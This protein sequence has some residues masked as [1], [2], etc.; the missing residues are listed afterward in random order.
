MSLVLTVRRSRL[1]VGAYRC[2]R[3]AVLVLGCVLAVV[4]EA[5]AQAASSLAAGGSQTCV[6]TAG[7]AV[8]CWGS[9]YAGLSSD[10]ES[11]LV[12]ISPTPTTVS[13]L[14][15]GVASVVVGDSHACAL[16][17]GGA[18]RCWGD[19]SSG[20]LGDGTTT[21]RFTPTAV[22]GLGSGVAA[23][24]AGDFHTCALTTGG[25]VR[26]W[27]A[28]FSGQLG[29]G[30]T[31]Y[32]LTPTF[33]SG[34]GSVAAVAVSGGY[35]HTC[36]LLATGAA[37]CWGSNFSGQ[38]GDGTTTTRSTP[39]AVSGL[40]SGVAAVAAR[41]SH[42]C[43]VTTGGALLCWGDNS[44][45]QLGDGT[46]TNRSTP[47][48]VSGLGAGVAAVSLGS[49]HTCA[50]TS[51]G[52]VRCWG[53]NRAGQLG[54]G[55]TNTYRY[56]PTEVTGLGAGVAALALG[57]SHSCARMV[58]GTVRCW[59]SNRGGQL[60]DGTASSP[61]ILVP[62]AS[63]LRSGVTALTA[64]RE[65]TC[66]AS[67]GGALLC[68]GQ[69]RSGQLGDGTSPT[70][71]STPTTVSGLASGVA[72]A[73]AGESHT[74]ALT[75]GGA[76]LCWGLN[77]SGQLGDGTSTARFTPTAVSG[78]ASGIAA[79]AA[80]TAHTCAL[81]TGGALG[82]WGGNGFGQIGDGGTGTARFTPWPVLGL[83]SGVAAMT[84]GSYHTCAL[85]TGGGVWCWGDN[86]FGQ[87]GDGTT[88]RRSAP[89]TVSGLGGG[90]AAIAAGAYHTCAVM[91]D[92]TVRCWGSNL[93]G[94][95]GDAT[96]VS[97]W[98]P[99]VVSGLGSVA[100][101]GAGQDHTCAVTT[102]GALWC[103]GENSS[104][105]LGD[106]TTTARRSPT[107]VSGIGNAAAV[108]L[109]R[110]NTCARTNIGA[111]Q[112]WGGDYD[113]QL[114][115]GTRLFSATPLP[116]YDLGGTTT[117]TAVAPAVGPANGG[118][119]VTITGSYFLQGA[120]VTF[121]GTPAQTVS[122][123]NTVEIVATTPA[124]APGVT[125]VVVTNPDG[126]AVTLAA[127]FTF[128]G[129]GTFTRMAPANGAG[130]QGT[131][132][133]LSWGAS[134]GA[135]SYAYCVDTT[136]DNQC[137]A[138]TSTG[139]ATS[140]GLNG[141][142]PGA[143]YYWH[144]RATNAS[145]TTY[146]N[147]SATAF[148]AFT[149]APPSSTLTVLRS[150]TGSGTVT[151]SP[152][153]ISCGTDCTEPYASGTVVTLIPAPAAGSVFGGWS[154]DA[155]CSDGTVTMSATRTCQATFNL[156]VPT[157]TR[158]TPSSG[159]LVGG[160]VLTISGTN[161]VA[162][163]T[164]SVGGVP[165]ISAA[166]VNPTTITAVTPASATT[167]AR[168]VVV[169]TTPGAT[170]GGPGL[171]T[172]LAETT[173][174]VLDGQ[175][176]LPP[177]SDFMQPTL[178]ADGRYLAYVVTN[179]VVIPGDSN[180]VPDVVVRDR[181]TGKVT[182]VSVAS[183]GGQSNGASGRPRISASGRYI[184]FWSD[185]TNIV[186]SDTN[187]VRDVFLHDRDADGN[188]VFDE[189]SAGARSTTR[190]SV[191]SN[192]AQADGAS[193]L[194][195]E[196]LVAGL[197]SDKQLDLSPDGLWV[198]FASV[199]RNLVLGDTN[200]VADIFLRNV[201]GQQTTRVSVAADG[202]EADGPSQGPG[203][204]AGAERIVF[205]SRA[206]NLVSG[207]TNGLS[208]VFLV[209]RA[210]G[211]VVPLSAAEGGTNADGASG[212]P[213]IDDAGRVVAFATRARN[214]VPALASSTTAQI[215]V[216]T[217]PPS[218]AVGVRAAAVTSGPSWAAS[219]AQGVIDVA[220]V[221]RQLASG[222]L[223][224]GTA[225]VQPGNGASTQPEVCGNGMCVGYATEATNLTSAP[226]I[227][228]VPDLV[229]QPVT[230]GA[231]APAP[232]EVVSNDSN[233][234]A[235]SEPSTEIALSED[236]G[237]VAMES[238]A[239]LTPDA[240]AGNPDGTNIFVRAL[241][242]LA[243][244]L[245]PVAAPV[246]QSTTIRVQGAGF[247]AGT[248]VLFGSV[249]R[250]GVVSDGGTT[251]TVTT[252]TMQAHGVVPGVV[253][254]TLRNPDG[255]TLPLGQAFTLLPAQDAT[256]LPDT[257]GD[258]L[259][260]DW[261][262]RYGLDASSGSGSQGATGDPDGDGR[263]N[264][265]ELAEG[266][267]PRGLHTRYFAEGVTSTFFTTRVALLNA[268]DGPAITQ[269]RFLRQGAGPVSQT[270]TVPARTR[271]AVY[272][273]SLPG[274]ATAE[275]ATVIESD[276][277]L[278]AD[279][280]VWWGAGAYGSHAE[281]PIEAP[282]TRWYFAEGATIG[283][284][285][286]F[287][288]LQNPAPA[289]ALVTIEYLLATA[290]PIMRTYTLPPNS[291]QTIWVNQEPGL[292]QAEVSAIISS[293]LP[294]NAER[295]MYLDRGGQLFAIGTVGAG[296]S[297]PATSWFIA[298]GATG[299]YF[300]QF[301][302]IGNP[303]LTPAAITARYL[304]PDGSQVVRQYA[305]PA[306]SRF[307][308]W[309]DQEGPELANTAASTLITADVPVLAEMSMWWPGDSR[310][311][312]EAHAAAGATLTGTVWAM[313]DGE[314][315]G[316]SNAETYVLVANTATYDALI[317]VTL[318]FEDGTTRQRTLPML[319]NS[320]F[321]VPIGAPVEAGGFGLE[322]VAGRAFGCVVESMS[323][324]AGVAPAQIVVERAMYS[325]AGGVRWAAG[326]ALLTTRIQ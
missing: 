98:T 10:G 219:T 23:L 30:T 232:I 46:V 105:Q 286:M 282:R 289:P 70:G 104:G 134:L 272:P 90:V 68:W 28:N 54:D 157:I 155:D 147:G 196:P 129:P 35:S 174:D 309:V 208:D 221:L 326:T 78:L 60:G 27:G 118:T 291:R 113:G 224:P 107:A 145:G 75:T 66:A 56:T 97:R 230:P 189:L 325:D 178:S 319:A 214:F 130:R 87:V 50:V 260:D 112:C 74:C 44:G 279:R 34:L 96:T 252:P 120:T 103:W 119:P 122:M 180:G 48:A 209:I 143:T 21:D 254:V 133:T 42:A 123:V 172:Y 197:A 248:V 5:H 139:A 109:G 199:A 238:A 53:Q 207:D 8:Q 167:G 148:W 36:V 85:T 161:F 80:G 64:G 47:T 100:A 91:T 179:D 236:G 65:H 251:L 14:G 253:R 132:V 288:T 202:T 126:R 166:V 195:G 301:I 223:P 81:T 243:A 211:Q 191:A 303:Q 77:S 213:S 128:Q 52:A 270:L 240:A 307:T 16:T 84:A 268:A 296:I 310:T 256:V 92:R 203:V 315:G 205:A 305:V 277:P 264:A 278:V 186:G 184:A 287:Y 171:F 218:A 297:E 159:P 271:S 71:R 225:V 190:V 173:D 76:A 152:T 285:Q 206:S 229:R 153:G 110:Y 6:V 299:P 322:A 89:T 233:G 37:R 144:V 181:V 261:E 314:V 12:T 188:G 226:D 101:L 18:V 235:A 26:C 255:S 17:T 108:A 131:S 293:D 265:Q 94:Q 192:G 237:V 247:T 204:S 72:A 269:V 99:T 175:P 41:G 29:D 127:A 263:T 19:N 187:A 20:Q 7:G 93:S 32:R 193:A 117:L 135:G 228:G 323:P 138:W 306:R 266:T 13:G 168:E 281:A 142:S 15:S 163:A 177:G 58:D 302:Q 62:V 82:C 3:W 258:G 2:S 111:V 4:S 24:T 61:S 140:V 141:L 246:D 217:L 114:G 9:S 321:N 149:V 313:A 156:T 151:S 284:F 162:G 220:E 294:I 115:V 124:R 31:T 283:G 57:G 242:V 300:D 273:G 249:V 201:K 222:V 59:G 154:G 241:P 290:P 245:S 250:E 200:G 158:V 102:A 51:S 318:Y 298:G 280:T 11:T 316:P 198:A 95:L 79:V 320:R 259:P 317:R 185:A 146:A 45:G 169:V 295:G 231:E 182:R 215:A 244:T 311:W 262:Q 304:Q 63:G 312:H 324:Q 160:T 165:A 88:T 39:T 150:G 1:R 86:S 73:A 194:D 136:N 116:V 83:Q 275:F 38:L 55:T 49:V 33:V 69:N 234:N 137:G 67:S 216:A 176:P 227:N 276:R 274:M 22:S 170:T 106:G 164:V 183:D 308:I 239:A 43:A 121:G 210:T 125:D 292:A 40:A 25:S 212:T 267:H 257:D